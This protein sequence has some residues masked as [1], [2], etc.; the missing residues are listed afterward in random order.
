M[1]IEEVL[2]KVND[3]CEEKQF[4]NATLTDSFKNKF[5]DHFAKAYP[6]GDINDETVINALKF[7][8]NTAFSSAS[9]LATLKQTEFTSKE[10]GLKSKIAELTKKLGEKKEEKL[11]IPDE[12]QQQLKELQEF[13]DENKRKEK[14]KSI[15]GIA[16]KSIRKDF[17]PSFEN[18]ASDYD[19]DDNEEEEQAKWLVKRF[20]EIVR[21]TIGDIKPLAPKQEEKR[22]EDFIASLK[23]IKVQ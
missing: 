10:N 7:S 9:E 17:H 18:F 15:I 6:E 5:A 2:Q 19:V 21:P 4:T 23:K 16:K 3:Y 8:L 1:N 13:K 14:L 12:I 22:D 20:Q 11:D